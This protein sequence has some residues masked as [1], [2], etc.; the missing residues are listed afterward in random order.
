MDWKFYG[1]DSE[2]EALNRILKRSR[3][4]FAKI[5]GRRRIGKT[6]LI[7]RALSD[8]PD[9][10]SFYVQIPDSSPAGVLSGVCDALETFSMSPADYPYPDT[11]LSLAKLIAKM[12]RDGIIVTLD[13]FQYFNR[14]RFKEFCSF[15]QKE[16]D[17]LAA[18]AENVKGGLFVL[19]SI[20]TEMT[21]LLEDRSAPLYNR[22][23][24][25]IL[26]GHL[27][28]ASLLQML[29]EHNCLEPGYLLFLWN[30]FE[31]VPKFYRDCYEQDVLGKPRHDVIRR[32]FFESSSPL[33]NEAEN[34]FLKELHGRY[35]AILQYIARKS[36]CSHSDLVEHVRTVSREEKEQV[37]GYLKT[38][39]GKYQ[40]VEKRLPI[41]AKEKTRSGKY[42]ISDNFL[43]AWLGALSTPASAAHFTPVANLVTKTDERLMTM[44][45]R[46]FEKLIGVIYEERS[47]KGIGDFVLSRRI[48]GY[49]DRAGVE[50]DFVAVDETNRRIRFGNC[51]RAPERLAPSLSDFENHI[52][53]YFNAFCEQTNWQIEKVCFAPLIKT[54]LRE[55]LSD[56]GY[57]VEDLMDL[58]SGLV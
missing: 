56:Q 27:E 11:L 30:L 43:R 42:F 37:G 4:F 58:F 44:E 15:L 16:V 6:S 24:D 45:G 52:K 21:A 32:M 14:P 7:Q 26:L 18:D 12:A 19:G 29:R 46:A 13:E 39:V 33:K 57:I 9:K 20:H 31:G 53:K 25:E 23:T 3:W 8:I 5:T 51:K 22:T 54:S 48:A 38:L 50:I 17:Q 2:I 10:K 40:L 49:W 55:K 34:W 35:D 41:F 28:I 36:G 1:R 47:R